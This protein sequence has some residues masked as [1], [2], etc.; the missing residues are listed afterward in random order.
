M[1]TVLERVTRSEISEMVWWCFE[2]I[3]LTE[4]AQEWYIFQRLLG[5][6]GG[7]FWEHAA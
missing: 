2:A 3:G 4:P 6:D 7:V 1:K 5:G